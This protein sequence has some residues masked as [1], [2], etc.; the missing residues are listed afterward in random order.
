MPRITYRGR[1]DMRTVQA[2]ATLCAF[3]ICGILTACAS[4]PEGPSPEEMRAQAE[5]SRLASE[6][7]AA[8]NTV[9]AVVPGS[10]PLYEGTPIAAFTPA[11]IQA[12]CGMTWDSRIGANG[13]TEYNPCRRQDAFSGTRSR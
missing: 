5:A 10:P 8:V 3:A 11:Q 7:D 2:S 12:Y 1:C 4:E 6:I 13:R 9:T